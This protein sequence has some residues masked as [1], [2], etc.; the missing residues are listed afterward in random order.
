[1]PNAV[2]SYSFLDFE[3]GESSGIF[4]EH[5]DDSQVEAINALPSI[6]RS[7]DF[8]NFNVITH[9]TIMFPDEKQCIFGRLNTS[10]L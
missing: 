5:V 8:I 10:I 9:F 2:L 6:Q 4:Y 7:Y 1:M 3:S